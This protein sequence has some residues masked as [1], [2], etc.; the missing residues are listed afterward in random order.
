MGRCG[1]REIVENQAEKTSAIVL[2][3][4]TEVAVAMS[5][6][7]EGPIKSREPGMIVGRVAIDHTPFGILEAADLEHQSH[8]IFKGMA[9]VAVNGDELFERGD[10][11]IAAFAKDG[12]FLFFFLFLGIELY[13]DGMVYFFSRVGPEE[14][15][16]FHSL[17]F[18]F[19][20]NLFK[21]GLPGFYLSSALY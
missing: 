17:Y 11:M 9:V 14:K 7:G 5:A 21:W 15:K 13:C 10:F 1:L 2:V 4:P 3:V 19:F 12:S 18:I 16:W 20:F 8:W 6:M